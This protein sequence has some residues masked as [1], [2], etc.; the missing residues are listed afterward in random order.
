VE[1]ERLPG[2]ARGEGGYGSTGGSVA[3]ADQ[4]AVAR[5]ART[6]PAVTETPLEE[7]Q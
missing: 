5:T 7:T 4:S 1:V 2:S 3:P 6:A